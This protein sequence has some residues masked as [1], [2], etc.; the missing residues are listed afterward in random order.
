MYTLIM[1]IFIISTLIKL[2]CF[3]LSTWIGGYI[4]YGYTKKGSIKYVYTNMSNIYYVY[5]NMGYIYHLYTNKGYTDRGYID[6]VYTDMGCICHFYI[7]KVYIN[8]TECYLYDCAPSP[9][10]S[11]WL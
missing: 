2:Q 1:L 9:A 6:F 11:Y 8:I 4:Y 3:I 10:L 7:Y 5:T